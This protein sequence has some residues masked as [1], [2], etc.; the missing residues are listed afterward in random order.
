MSPLLEVKDLKVSYY[1]KGDELPAL[2]GISLKLHKGESLGISGESGCGKSTLA[3]AILG[4]IPS[5]EGGVKS[6][7]VLFDKKNLLKLSSKDMR[8]I[9]GKKI[10]L[11]MQDPYGSFNPVIKLKSQ[12]LETGLVHGMESLE[13]ERKISSL[14][15]AVQLPQDVRE[16]YPHQLSG[17]MLQRVS[18]V[19]ALIN[20]PEILIA[21]E[22]TS[23]LDVTI[24]KK[25]AQLLLSLKE[26]FALSL[27]F[28]T[29]N[30]NLLSLMA[31]NIY[32]LYAGELLEM[33][34]SAS[35]FKN[36]AH[37]YTKGLIDA[38]P[39]IRSPGSELR[40]IPGSIPSPDKIPQGCVFRPR[41]SYVF[42]KCRLSPPLKE[43]V[44][45]HFYRCHL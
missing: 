45:G 21:D 29:H 24:Q 27:I 26:R 43:G 6:G 28:I 15:D 19:A 8:Q 10:S 16:A 37:P 20:S 9:R 3:S 2:R 7:E 40:P 1:R 35:L 44:F 14:L 36:P 39:D 13:A 32:I 38:L 33:G 11:I 23:S 18:I 4:L 22:S 42:E 41:C 5:S 17:G 12:L 34:P 31:D 25:I 30:L